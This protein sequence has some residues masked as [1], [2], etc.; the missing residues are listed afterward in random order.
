M[1]PPSGNTNIPNGSLASAA[2]KTPAATVLKHLI[3]TTFFT[4]DGVTSLQVYL[5]NENKFET[6]HVVSYKLNANWMKTKSK[7]ETHHVVSCQINN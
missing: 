2:A 6:P 4:D 5:Y 3:S 7:L 1:T